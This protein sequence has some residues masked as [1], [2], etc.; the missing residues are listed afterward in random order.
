MR[1][2]CKGKKFRPRWRK[3]AVA[4]AILHAL[5]DAEHGAVSLLE[6]INS[7]VEPQVSW[8]TIEDQSRAPVD[9]KIAG[10]I[11]ARSNLL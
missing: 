4:E 8:I 3:V 6:L 11:F 5:F 2:S 10:R 7:P 1:M 9:S